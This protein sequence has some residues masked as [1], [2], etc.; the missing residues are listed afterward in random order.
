MIPVLERAKT[1]YALDSATTLI[2][3]LAIIQ[4]Y[5]ILDTESVVKYTINKYITI[6]L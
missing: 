3:I 1:F 4:C 2:R 6:F 5:I